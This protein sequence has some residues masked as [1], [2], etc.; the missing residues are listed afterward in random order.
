LVPVNREDAALLNG[1]SSNSN[2]PPVE[3]RFNI[4]GADSLVYVKITPLLSS[5]NVVERELL[6]VQL[7]PM[8]RLMATL[9]DMR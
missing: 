9:S 5:F 8:F 2:A 3:I 6:P 7:C 1:T 4:V